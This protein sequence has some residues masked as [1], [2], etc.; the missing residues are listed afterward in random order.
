MRA[1]SIRA[2]VYNYGDSVTYIITA[3]P[4]YHLVSVEVDGV[5]VGN[6]NT[7]TFAFVDNNHT[8]IAHFETVGIEDIDNESIT[9]YSSGQT[10]YVRNEGASQIHSVEVYDVTGRRVA[11]I[12]NV[13][14]P[15]QFDL[16]V[17]SGTYIVRVIT[18]QGVLSRKVVLTR[19]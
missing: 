5:N 9:V 1:R 17:V 13:V 15:W 3:L 14:T 4:G 10:I 7:Y 19:W 18:D 2:Q 8:I 12:M 6:D 11:Q 16:S